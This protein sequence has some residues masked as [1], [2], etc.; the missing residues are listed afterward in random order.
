MPKHAPM[1]P[2]RTGSSAPNPPELRDPLH[3]DG[4]LGHANIYGVKQTTIYLP[5]DLKK[6]LELV[7]RQEGRTEA[8]IVRE[9]LAD[10]LDRR[11]VSP[12][13]S[14]F[15]EGWGDSALAERVDELLADTGFGR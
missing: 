1:A 4:T 12:T 3:S 13:V 6:R 11:E 7:A 8:A 15:A 5:D 9:A 2:S 14:L 10:A